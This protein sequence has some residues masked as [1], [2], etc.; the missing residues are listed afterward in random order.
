MKKILTTAIFGLLIAVPAVGANENWTLDN[1]EGF[2][3]SGN[4]AGT[5]IMR[6]NYLYVLTD[7]VDGVQVH[8]KKALPVDSEWE[9]VTNWPFLQ[10][11]GNTAVS[12]VLQWSGSQK[13]RDRVVIA[14]E[15]KVT[16]A[17]VWRWKKDGSWQQINND[18]FGDPEHSTVLHMVRYYHSVHFS[19]RSIVAF[20]DD[21]QE[22]TN[23]NVLVLSR[24]LKGSTTNWDAKTT[25]AWQ[26]FTDL[27]AAKVFRGYIYIANGDS[28]KI[29][30]SE[31]AVDFTQ[32]A[33]VDGKITGFILRSG[34]P[35]LFALGSAR[36]F[37]YEARQAFWRTKNGSDWTNISSRPN[38]EFCYDVA[39]KR[40]VGQMMVGGHALGGFHLY[41]VPRVAQ[42]TW[43]TETT[44]AFGDSE[45]EALLDVEYHRRWYVIV[46]HEDGIRVYRK[47]TESDT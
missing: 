34:R 30:R 45:N 27:D 6:G 39:G 22:T 38:A 17:E 8:K 12:A 1:Q 18:G 7:N 15:N 42:G 26:S 16:G 36:R 28:A 32:V 29:W 14:L 13:P 3:D 20:V 47:L 10:D 33:S 43:Q 40:D 46:E 2:G 5:F 41:R 31:N 19:K 9:E 23:A 11:S 24:Q 4:T 35:A 21:P 37:C 25:L 44:D